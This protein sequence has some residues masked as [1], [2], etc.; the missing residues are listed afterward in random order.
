MLLEWGAEVNAEPAL[1]GTALQAAAA[2]GN[3][4]RLLLEHGAE[5][6]ADPNCLQKRPLLHDIARQGQVEMLRLLLEAKAD[7]SQ[8][9]QSGW[10]PL[11]TASFAGYTEIMSLL[12]EAKADATATDDN[13][14][15]VL[16]LPTNAATAKLLLDTK[17][18]VRTEWGATLNSDVAP[19]HDGGW[20]ALHVASWRGCEDVAK[21][22]LENQADIFA[23]TVKGY[24]GLHLASENGHEGVVQLFL[25]AN[26]DPDSL[27]KDR[28]TPLHCG[29]RAGHVEVVDTLLKRTG[30]VNAQTTYG[31]TA[32]FF[33]SR[34]GNTEIVE[35]LL[36]AKADPTTCTKDGRIPLH[37]ASEIGQLNIVDILL[38]TQ[39]QAALIEDKRGWNALHYAAL[40][41][42][43]RVIDVLIRAFSDL[44]GLGVT[45]SLSKPEGLDTVR[46]LEYLTSA[47][48]HD[49]VLLRSLGTEYRRRNRYEDARK[50]FDDLVHLVQTTGTRMPGL[51]A[52]ANFVDMNSLNGIGSSATS[53]G[54][55]VHDTCAIGK[56]EYTGY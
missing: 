45:S 47:Y 24:T 41:G 13:G 38:D 37:I 39:P 50:T 19:N 26:M 49:A 7:V 20:T 25:E 31:E 23:K 21:I 15:T 3:E 22:L 54:F 33:A 16:H 9:N 42:H 8:R 18:D 52:S 30:D 43:F 10:T 55:V 6:N 5:V 12:L 48:P 53:A 34:E 35:M 28:F 27:T 46:L 32:L 40:S 36:G 11:H 51:T 1:Y 14:L 44:T 29:S 4:V 17:S 2:P 56:S